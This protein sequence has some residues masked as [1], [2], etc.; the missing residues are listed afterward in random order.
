MENT[1]PGVLAFAFLAA[2]LY[3]GA[4]LRMRV[5]LIQTYLVPASIVGGVL[6]FAVL[7]LGLAPTLGGQE[8]TADV[9]MPFT[10]HFF[11]LSFMSLV[12]TGANKDGGGSRPLMLGGLWLAFLWTGSLVLQ[13]LT[14]LGVFEVYNFITGA[15]VDNVLGMLVAHG[16]TQG[17]GQALALGA[18]WEAEF[19][20]K[21]AASI[22]VVY[23]SF[24]FIVSFIVGVP[25]ARSIVS[26]GLNENRDAS[27]DDEFLRGAY[28]ND[29]HVQLGRHITHP[30]NL[31]SLAFHLGLLGIGYVLTDLWLANMQSIVGEAKLGEIPVGL[32]FSYN[33]FFV[34]GLIVC[35]IM[36]AI[37][38]RMEWGYLIDDDTQRMVTGTSVDL[39]VV[40][41]ILSI[42]ISVLA[43]LW[44]PVLAVVVIATF[45]TAL[46]CF[47]F[48]RTSEKFGYE[49]S[50]ASFGCCCGSTGTGLLLLRILDPD[51]R[52]PVAKELA[53]FN[54]AIL[55][56][57]IHILLVMAPILPSL[58]MGL[59]LSVYLATLVV[60]GL[61]VRFIK[62]G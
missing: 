55:V 48:A 7:N 47:T 39:M 30:S 22:G 41:T 32:F 13:A 53:F 31:E 4:I 51:F 38:D 14:G 15:G 61:G 29:T 36:R 11:T 3:A 5:A 52:T 18:I 50:L 56:T 59:I 54:I 26:R 60:A 43:T 62:I 44:A 57:T 12:L 34:H 16:F 6:G 19:D 1:F 42:K 23:A 25:V 45:V 21:D 33:L 58:S 37:I 10:F 17:P 24:G 8:Q 2:M 46:L 28:N 9:F 49:R 35:S 40:A 27:I 20:I